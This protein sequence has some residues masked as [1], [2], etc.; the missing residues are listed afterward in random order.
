M[1]ELIQSI[2]EKLKTYFESD[3]NYNESLLLSIVAEKTDE[4]RAARKYPSYYTE[5]MIIEDLH[6]YSSNIYRG[7]KNAYAKIGA[8]GESSHSENGI[9]RNYVSETAFLKGVVPIAR[10]L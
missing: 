2:F 6:C 4:V 3:E 7:A 1:D 8:E 5:D 9:S 10:T